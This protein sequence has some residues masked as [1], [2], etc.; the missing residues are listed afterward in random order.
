MTRELKLI[1]GGIVIFLLIL[2][3]AEQSS[4]LPNV[5]ISAFSAAFQGFPNHPT[6]HDFVEWGT[7]CQSHQASQANCD[8]MQQ[9]FQS[10]LEECHAR[11]GPKDFLS[12]VVSGRGDSPIAT[13]QWCEE[14]F[15]DMK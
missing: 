12:A 8:K 15:P 11:M 7:K 1:F 9:E 10:R 6:I 4:N 14:R 3:V 5:D 13:L 2:V